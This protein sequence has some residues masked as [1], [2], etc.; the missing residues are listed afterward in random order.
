MVDQVLSCKPKKRISILKNISG[1]ELAFLGHFKD[2]AVMPGVLILETMIQ[3]ALLLYA[4]GDKAPSFSLRH[5]KIRF[6][7]PVLPGDQMK[8]DVEVKEA[9]KKEF[10]F[11]GRALVEDR[12]MSKGILTFS[13]GRKKK[14]E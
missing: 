1:N 3:G 5:T 4:K 14:D 7:Q 6:L 2:R 9:S 12:L 13:N 11:E 8:V 10:V